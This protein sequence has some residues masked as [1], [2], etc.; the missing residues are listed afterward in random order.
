MH[1]IVL[2]NVMFQVLLYS[3][4]RWR[5][6]LRWWCIIQLWVEECEMW[7]C[8]SFWEGWSSQETYRIQPGNVAHNRDFLTMSA[9]FVLQYSKPFFTG[10]LSKSCKKCTVLYTTLTVS[11]LQL[12]RDRRWW[13][14]CVIGS[15][16]PIHFTTQSPLPYSRLDSLCHSAPC[17]PLASIHT[18]NSH[19][20]M[21]T[22]KNGFIQQLWQPWRC[23]WQHIISKKGCI[24]NDSL[25]FRT[26]WNNQM[27]VIDTVLNSPPLLSP[28]LHIYIFL[29][30]FN[31]Y[32]VDYDHD[33][34]ST[35][36]YVWAVLWN[37]WMQHVVKNSMR[38]RF[39][40]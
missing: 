35:V 17:V 18:T 13:G 12:G 37:S 21:L 14:H 38:P 29:P 11:T 34:M 4:E 33:V 30:L 24:W 8:V 27:V 40:T 10:N 19:Q 28:K 2:F 3:S 20:L 32:W 39:V 31:G 26:K 5:R 36:W 23:N 16:C 25:H 1:I 15:V 7:K 22:L 9:H 6:F